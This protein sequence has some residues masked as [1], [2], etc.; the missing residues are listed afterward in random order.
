MYVGLVLGHDINYTSTQLHSDIFDLLMHLLLQ[1][2]IHGAVLPQMLVIV[3]R[4][5]GQLAQGS[6]V[7]LLLKLNVLLDD[8]FQIFIHKELIKSVTDLIFA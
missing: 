4:I 6:L 2:L 5:S 3:S 8:Y 7:M 1:T